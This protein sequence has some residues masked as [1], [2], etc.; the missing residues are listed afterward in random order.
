MDKIT[1]E[2][3]NQ[4]GQTTRVNAEKYKAMHDAIVSVLTG[5]SEPLDYA[6]IKERVKP[7]L[8]ESLFPGGAT[9]GWW[10]KC[11]QLDLEA[12]GRMMRTKDKPLR[13]NLTGA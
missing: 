2:N 5:Q 7:L 4:P 3:V 1:V 13:F 8:P 12:K 11:V 6:A 9:S 10:I